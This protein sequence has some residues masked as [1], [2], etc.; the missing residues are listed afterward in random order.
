MEIKKLKLLEEYGIDD[1]INLINHNFDRYVGSKSRTSFEWGVWSREMNIE[2][3]RRMDEPLSD[4]DQVLLGLVFSYW[5]TVSQ[6]LD[7]LQNKERGIFEK[8]FLVRKTNAKVDEAIA[9]RKHITSILDEN[10]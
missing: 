8:L 3:K 7:L 6:L 9:I 4:R 5:V 1:F 10:N 2:I